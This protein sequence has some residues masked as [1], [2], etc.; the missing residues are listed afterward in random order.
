MIRSDQILEIQSLCELDRPFIT[1]FDRSN[2]LLRSINDYQPWLENVLSS[3]IDDRWSELSGL[4]RELQFA[5]TVKFPE[6]STRRSKMVPWSFIVDE[7][8]VPEVYYWTFG[9]LPPNY[10]FTSNG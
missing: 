3:C 8:N 10:E 2:S 4:D 1:V 6:R 7:M 5:D 9:Q